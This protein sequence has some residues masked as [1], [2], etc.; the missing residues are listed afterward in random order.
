MHNFRLFSFIGGCIFTAVTASAQ[1]DTTTD[2]L[3]QLNSGNVKKAEYTTATFKATRIINGSSVENV[4]K[5]VLDFRIMHRFGRLDQGSQNFYGLDNATTSLGLD[6]G[7]TKWLMVGLSHS[8]YKKE[9]EGFLKAKLLRQK[10]KGGHMPVSV[11]Y[12]G[13]VSVQTDESDPKPATL[14]AG[15]TYYFS[16]R[17]VFVN[18]V[19]I[20]RKFNDWLSLQLTPTHIHYNLV[21]KSSYSNDVFAVGIGGRIKLS[22][23]FALTGEYYY[24]S[25]YGTGDAYHNSI[26]VGVD[27]ETGGHVFQ[28][29][30]TNTTSMTE[31]TFIAQTTDDFGKGQIHFGFNVTR[32][33]TI[34]RPKEFK[35]SRNGIY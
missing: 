21:D 34:V 26:S 8:T 12:F 35:H 30:F 29:H 32:V 33:F 3:S 23:R 18:Q 14:P 27:I 22:N 25:P 4:G 10:E 11:S 24:V 7:I 5:G 9:N 13:A 16:N 6:Y 1:T 17:L 28:L 2:L 31:R 20:A 19:L 15:D